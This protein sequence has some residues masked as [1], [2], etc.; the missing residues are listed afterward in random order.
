VGG[1]VAVEGGDQPGP[2]RLDQ[3]LGAGPAAVAKAAGQPLGQAQVGQD[4]PLSQ[5]G[6]AAG[7][8]GLQPSLDLGRGVLVAWGGRPGPHGWKAGGWWWTPGTSWASSTRAAWTGQ[9]PS[10]GWS[11]CADGSQ[12]WSAS[13]PSARQG[14]TARASHHVSTTNRSGDQRVASTDRPVTHL[15]RARGLE[16]LTRRLDVD[17]ATSA[18]PDQPRMLTASKPPCQPTSDRPPARQVQAKAAAGRFP[19]HLYASALQQ[20]VGRA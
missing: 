6:V 12:T 18:Q 17:V 20:L 5:L 14:A 1:V 13:R 8:V 16:P 9:Q 4:D 19:G 3:V 15:A 10:S 2:G 7:G 11:A